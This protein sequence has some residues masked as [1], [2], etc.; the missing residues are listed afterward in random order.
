M[1]RILFT[2]AFALALLAPAAS[3]HAIFGLGGCAA[4]GTGG[5]AASAAASAT[6]VKV[7]DPDV[8]ANQ[9]AQTAKECVL[10]G[11]T[12]VLAEALISS[13]TDNIVSWINSGFEGGPA[14]VTDLN[15]FLG[16]VANNVSVDFIQG[17]E[18]GFLCSP[19]EIPVRLALIEGYETERSFSNHISCS[20][21]DVTN[22]IDGFLGGDFSQGGWEAWFKLHLEP[23]NN[24]YGALS[25]AE[26][27]RVSRIVQKQGV[28]LK[29]L[30]FGSG[31]FSKGECHFRGLTNYSVDEEGRG[32]TVVTPATNTQQG[33][34][35]QG[36]EW[37]IVTPGS[38]VNELLAKWLGISADKLAVADEIDE[39]INALLAQLSQQIFTSLSGLRGLSSDTSTSAFDG[40]SYVRNLSQGADSATLE[41]ARNALVQDM[42]VAIDFE[43][44]YRGILDQVI[45]AYS[46]A[47]NDFE[48]VFQQC[49]T[50]GNT[51]V[52]GTAS[53]TLALGITPLLTDYE[54]QKTASIETVAQLV[55]IRGQ[56]QTANDAASLNAAGDA[57][58]AL[59]DAGVIHVSADILFLAQE[60]DAQQ[61]SLSTFASEAATNFAACGGQT[62]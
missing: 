56:A 38:Q 10:D 60:R 35:D 53:S 57:Y 34:T 16:D 22:N 19:I 46:A 28:E 45:I 47:Q 31:F 12:S 44:T 55:T 41:V 62:P 52:A 23:Q 15:G 32:N 61:G 1:K 24:P 18:L 39:I 7:D 26:N 50:T 3:A 6:H 25:I 59:I 20:L 11:L 33:C 58:Q 37:V 14:Y 9:A 40:R 48:Q 17:S 8:S 42:N 54:N 51:T 43:E 27:E 13:I 30:D 4:A 36:G 49:T 2:A 21:G 29:L 5:A